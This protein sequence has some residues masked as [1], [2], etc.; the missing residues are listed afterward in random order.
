MLESLINGTPVLGADIG[1]IPELIDSTNGILFKSGDKKDLE[2]KIY[3]ISSKTY[4][5]QKIGKEA[6]QKY[7]ASK[8]INKL[9]N[10]YNQ[11]ITNENY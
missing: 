11:A 8:Y 1:G 10:L 9:T 6:Q 5:Y 2:K 4:N 3:E 7:S